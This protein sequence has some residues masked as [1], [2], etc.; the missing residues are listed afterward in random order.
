[1]P[2]D[3]LK[4]DSYGKT[5]IVN[6][7]AGLYCFLRKYPWGQEVSSYV[8]VCVVFLLQGGGFC[9][10]KDRFVLLLRSF[11]VPPIVCWGWGV[12]PFC[13]ADFVP[14]IDDRYGVG[15]CGMVYLM[16]DC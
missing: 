16:A 14:R 2:V 4:Y 10:H 9:R 3:L 12:S 7:R 8:L 6:D 15:V 13:L 1:M 11:I 5:S